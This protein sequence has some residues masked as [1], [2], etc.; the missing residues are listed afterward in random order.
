MYTRIHVKKENLNKY[1]HNS[2]NIAVASVIAIARTPIPW[3]N[4]VKYIGVHLL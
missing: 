2:K 1:K 3:T 4:K